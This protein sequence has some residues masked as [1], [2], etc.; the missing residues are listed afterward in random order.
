MYYVRVP[1]VRNLRWVSWGQHQGFD[2]HES[3]PAALGE[4]QFP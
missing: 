1:E 3:L 4:N 2:R